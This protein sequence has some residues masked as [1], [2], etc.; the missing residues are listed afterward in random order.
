MFDAEPLP[1]VPE[2]LFV[3]CYAG[4]CDVDGVSLGAGE[5][6]HVSADGSV[7]V[8]L[9]LIPPFQADDPWLDDVSLNLYNEL[10]HDIGDGTF[11]CR[12]AL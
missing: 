9:A 5:A 7:K 3:S 1:S 4:D 6:A 8:R 12:V 11:E 10:T 2:G